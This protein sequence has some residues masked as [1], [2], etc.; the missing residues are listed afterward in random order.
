MDSLTYCVFWSVVLLIV[1][2]ICALMCYL[3]LKSLRGI[4]FQLKQLKEKTK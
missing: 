2:F 3:L 4:E 1:I